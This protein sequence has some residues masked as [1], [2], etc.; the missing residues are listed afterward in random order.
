MLKV[1]TLN[2]FFYYLQDLKSYKSLKRL[3]NKKHWYSFISIWIP[4]I[5][6]VILKRI[7]KFVGLNIFTFR[8]VEFNYEKRLSSYSNIWLWIIEVFF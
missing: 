5:V 6:N 4:E 7:L 2:I 1:N 3:F 8:K